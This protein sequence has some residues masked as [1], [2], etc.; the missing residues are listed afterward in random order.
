MGS[1]GSCLRFGVAVLRGAGLK[2]DFQIT[3]ERFN[4]FSLL[5]CPE[6]SNHFGHPVNDMHS[7]IYSCTIVFWKEWWS[8]L[9]FIERR[10][11]VVEAKECIFHHTSAILWIFGQRRNGQSHPRS[12]SPFIYKPQWFCELCYSFMC[13]SSVVSNAHLETKLPKRQQKD[14]KRLLLWREM[15]WCCCAW[16][17]GEVLVKIELSIRKERDSGGGKAFLIFLADLFFKNKIMKKR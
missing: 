9:E 5:D 7:N 16:V 4:Q 10:A 6:L 8:I 15:R 17:F 1:N 11:T 2:L 3:F 13:S 12:S 14:L